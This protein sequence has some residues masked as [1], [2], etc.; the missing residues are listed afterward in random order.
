M[1]CITTLHETKSRII[2]LT[3]N[4]RTS[5]LKFSGHSKR[6]RGQ[7]LIKKHNHTEPNW[8]KSVIWNWAMYYAIDTLNLN[9]SY[10]PRHTNTPTVIH[11]E[12]MLKSHTHIS[13]HT[14]N[15]ILIVSYYHGG[16]Y[17]YISFGSRNNKQEL[18]GDNW[19][20]LAHRP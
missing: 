4:R 10:P 5:P 11:K 20:L 13:Q 17:V 12:P 14:S 9:H 3:K 6:L 19:M 7:K 1:I 16:T 15:A 8:E 18:R 2:C